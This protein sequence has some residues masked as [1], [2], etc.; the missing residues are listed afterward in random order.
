MRSWR[1]EV[2]VA[3]AG[4]GA[5]MLATLSACSAD[6]HMAGPATSG[7]VALQS[8]SPASGTTGVSLTMPM[9][10][11]FSGAM[12]RGMESYML[13]HEGTVT[14]PVVAGRWS[15]SDDR[16]TLTFTPDAPLRARTTYLIHMGGGMR[17]ADGAL[18]DYGSCAGLGGRSVSAGMMAG[19]GSRMMGSG[20]LGSGWQGSDGG[21]GMIF[22]FTT[23]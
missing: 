5:L 1:R 8:V 15:W 19:G 12:G 3:V 13:V 7:R 4:V 22:T 16:R 23:A 2:Q 17:A 20:W 14:G 18:L 6:S 9:T 11:Q 10:M 21:Y